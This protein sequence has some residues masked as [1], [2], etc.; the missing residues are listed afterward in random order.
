MNMI[1]GIDLGTTNS[2]VS[3]FSEKGTVIIPN[4]FGEKLTPS[5]VSFGDNG[6]VYVGKVAKERMITHPESTKELFKR[7]MGSK[8]E[9]IINENKVISI[10]VYESKIKVYLYN[11]YKDIL[12]MLF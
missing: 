3:Y 2:L 12:F 7:S 6:E 10:S 8:K 5:V 9:F 4:R 11:L 1:I